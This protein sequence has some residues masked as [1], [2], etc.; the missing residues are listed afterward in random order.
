[1]IVGLKTHKRNS[2][3]NDESLSR[4]SVEEKTDTNAQIYTDHTLHTLAKVLP[5]RRNKHISFFTLD[6]NFKAVIL[7]DTYKSP[8][9]KLYVFYI[10]DVL[11]SFFDKSKR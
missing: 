2:N 9:F 1:M 8:L 4:K 10:A 3:K 11:F 6:I 7:S 5:Y